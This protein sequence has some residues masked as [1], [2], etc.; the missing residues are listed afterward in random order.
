MIYRMK[1]SLY[2]ELRKSCTHQE[3]IGYVNKVFLHHSVDRI[4]QVVIY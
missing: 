4:I 2:D 3:I 1:K